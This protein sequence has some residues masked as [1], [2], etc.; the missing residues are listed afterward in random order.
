MAIKHEITAFIKE[1]LKQNTPKS[2]IEY[3]L[4][5]KYQKQDYENI[6]ND[7]PEQNFKEKYTLLNW[8]LIGS[9]SL[10]TVFKIITILQTRS[11]FGTTALISFIIIGIILPIILIVYLAS[12][13]A[14]GFLLT[15]ALTVISIANNLENNV[16]ALSS[17]ENSIDIGL[18]VLQVILMG[19]CIILPIYVWRKAFPNYKFMSAFSKKN[20]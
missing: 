5:R 13:R 1:K 18:I 20:N 11:E 2:Q 6:L 3:Q 19:V 14:S 15:T 17:V 16:K 8:I 7:F 10:L 4:S 9:L 12:F